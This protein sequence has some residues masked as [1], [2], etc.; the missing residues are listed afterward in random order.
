MSV[1]VIFGRVWEPRVKS[2]HLQN[3][4]YLTQGMH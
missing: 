4:I 3:I 1:L 2:K